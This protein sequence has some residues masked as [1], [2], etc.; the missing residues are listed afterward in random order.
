M[1]AGVSKLLVKT[2]DILGA[3]MVCYCHDDAVGE[4][5]GF[6]GC[7]KLR[8][9]RLHMGTCV[10]QD[11]R[12]IRVEEFARRTEGSGV[13]GPLAYDVDRL[14]EHVGWQNDQ[15][16]VRLSMCWSSGNSELM[17]VVSC[18]NEGYEPTAVCDEN[19]I[20]LSLHTGSRQAAA[21]N[22]QD[23]WRRS[24]LAAAVLPERFGVVCLQL[25]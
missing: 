6:R 24:W 18:R 23:P 19:S 7:L 13:A 2:E 25:R 5:Y 15:P 11:K 16:L 12:T 17:I 20:I 1:I 22:P 14:S 8:E 3:I 10:D 21:T 4:A 9:S